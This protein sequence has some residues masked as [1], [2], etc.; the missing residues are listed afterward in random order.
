MK[1]TPPGTPTMATKVDPTAR[2]RTW[3]SAGADGA[4]ANSRSRRR[5][6]MSRML[7]SGGARQENED[8]PLRGIE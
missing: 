8:L 1:S 2:L 4:S 6:Y 3:L 7:W 5:P